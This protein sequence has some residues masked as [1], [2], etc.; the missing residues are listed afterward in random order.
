MASQESQLLAWPPG[1]SPEGLLG[2]QKLP[3]EEVAWKEGMNLPVPA[4]LLFPISKVHSV[5]TQLPP[6]TGVCQLVLSAADGEARPCRAHFIGVQKQWEEP[7]MALDGKMV[8]IWALPLPETDEAKKIWGGT[9]VGTNTGKLNLDGNQRWY[10]IP[11]TLSAEAT[12]CRYF[13][14]LGYLCSLSFCRFLEFCHRTS[15]IHFFFIHVL[16][17]CHSIAFIQHLL[18]QGIL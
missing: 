18:W 8:E 15:S 6:S 9:W 14:T 7:S 5:V 2:T 11:H 12:L 16:N 17:K 4:C 1:T 10:V 13:W 3:S